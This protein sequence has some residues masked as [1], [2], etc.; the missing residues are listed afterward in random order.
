MTLQ[1][2]FAQHF[3]RDDLEGAKTWFRKWMHEDEQ[4]IPEIVEAHG[5][6]PQFSQRA[7]AGHVSDYLEGFTGEEPESYDGSGKIY[8][9]TKYGTEIYFSA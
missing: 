4:H 5:D 7:M 8:W 3:Q 1:D 9:D 2:V 6:G